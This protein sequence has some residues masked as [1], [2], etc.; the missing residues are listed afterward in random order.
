M[1]KKVF[2]AAAG[3]I[4]AIVLLVWMFATKASRWLAVI[5]GIMAL[6]NWDAQWAIIAGC[7]FLFAIV[8]HILFNLMGVDV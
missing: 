7:S 4:S 6:W 3:T 2:V 5:F 1:A 8:S